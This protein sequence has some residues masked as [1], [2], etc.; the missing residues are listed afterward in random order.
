MNIIMKD[1]L[2]YSHHIISNQFSLNHSALPVSDVSHC[3]VVVKCISWTRGGA[4]HQTGVPR[5]WYYNC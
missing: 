4:A 5:G 1:S 2:S 3:H